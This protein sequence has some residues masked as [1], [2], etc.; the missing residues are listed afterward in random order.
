MTESTQCNLIPF[1]CILC[2]KRIK[3]HKALMSHLE[4]TDYH[5]KYFEKVVNGD[6]FPH[7]RLLKGN[8]S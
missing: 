2:G 6:K 7:S 5:I 3:T 8:L 1:D 4:K